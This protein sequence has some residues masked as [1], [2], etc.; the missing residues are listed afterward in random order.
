MWSWLSSAFGRSIVYLQVQLRLFLAPL[1]HALTRL[2][3]AVEDLD[4][5][6]LFQVI[7]H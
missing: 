7:Y 1:I 2:P 5:L 3:F 4:E 6:E